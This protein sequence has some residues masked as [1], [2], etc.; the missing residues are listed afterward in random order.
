MLRT[1][2]QREATLCAGAQLGAQLLRP[3]DFEHLPQEPLDSD[4]FGS[5]HGT[6][7]RTAWAQWAVLPSTCHYLRE[8]LGT[9]TLR[10]LPVT[11]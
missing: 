3:R 11:L 9:P 5:V 2:G 1:T 6:V 4:F 7:P 8:A 10:P